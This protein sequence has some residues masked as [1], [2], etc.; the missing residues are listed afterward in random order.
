VTTPNLDPSIR[1]H[2]KQD[3]NDLGKKIKQLTHK[4]I[5]VE[6]MNNSRSELMLKTKGTALASKILL[7]IAGAATAIAIA[8]VVAG[9]LGLV[10]T[11]V[12]ALAATGIGAAA[13]GVVAIAV[14][15]LIYRHCMM[16]EAG[17]KTDTGKQLGESAIVGGISFVCTAVIALVVLAFVAGGSGGGIGG[18]FSSGNTGFLHGFALGSL[19]GYRPIPLIVTAHSISYLDEKNSDEQTDKKIEIKEKIK[20]PDTIYIFRGDSYKIE[21]GKITI[22]PATK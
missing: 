15:I 2:S 13:V 9:T 1:V 7:G 18:G 10:A 19:M 16:K 5:K 3:A 14:G 22:T 21:E 11:G 8:V 20:N 6:F 12:A 4:E 17:L